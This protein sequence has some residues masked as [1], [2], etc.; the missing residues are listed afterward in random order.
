MNEICSW[1]RVENDVQYRPSPPSPLVVLISW[2]QPFETKSGAGRGE[3]HA[4]RVHGVAGRIILERSLVPAG[5]VLSLCP[6]R[7]LWK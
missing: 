1:A 2:F 7:R 5:V 3:D 4:N 6:Q